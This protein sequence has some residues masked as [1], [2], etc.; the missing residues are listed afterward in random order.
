VLRAHNVNELVRPAW[1]V[2][3]KWA[4][5]VAWLAGDTSVAPSEAVPSSWDHDTEEM[6]L[7]DDH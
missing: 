5:S 2:R 6:P 1:W 4:L 7:D 3:H